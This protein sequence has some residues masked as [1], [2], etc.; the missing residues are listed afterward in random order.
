MLETASSRITPRFVAR[1]ASAVLLLWFSSF[2]LNRWEYYQHPRDAALFYLL[3]GAAL[4]TAFGI[5]VLRALRKLSPLRLALFVLL[6]FLALPWG[7]WLKT[8][9]LGRES[10]SR[11]LLEQILWLYPL[12]VVFHLFP[13]LAGK[14]RAYFA[15]V[16]AY[17]A[18]QPMFLRILPFLFFL[19][20]A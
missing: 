3:F 19:I 13:E 6:A 1:H 17:L 2:I 9:V 20:A 15:K 11:Q 7:E 14:I 16:I 10:W 8:D 18:A 12:L 5:E 4:F